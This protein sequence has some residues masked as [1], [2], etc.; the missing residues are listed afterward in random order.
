[1]YHERP[2]VYGRGR[3]SEATQRIGVVLIGRN[4]GERLVRAL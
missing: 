2:G 3:M 4:E 1:L